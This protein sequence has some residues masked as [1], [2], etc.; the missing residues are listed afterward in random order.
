M[1]GFL[2]RL[3]SGVLHAQRAIHP[4]VGTIWTSAAITGTGMMEPPGTAEPIESSADNRVPPTPHGADAPAPPETQQSTQQP[5]KPQRHTVRSAQ[6][7][8]NA[9]RR[10]AEPSAFGESVAFEPLVTSPQRSAVSAQPDA[11][12]QQSDTIPPSR[13]QE[14]SARRAGL[15]QHQIESTRPLVPAPRILVPAMAGARKAPSFPPPSKRHAPPTQSVVEQPDSIE[16]HIGRIEVLAAPPRAAK[17]AAPA[18][19][20]KSL[21]LGEYLRRERRPQ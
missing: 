4:S 7:S 15:Q 18:P 12:M 6:P 9:G 20:R 16:I 10:E 21:D 19:A 17:P 3:A 1:S 5:A 2:Q 13:Q 14:P 11:A 8:D